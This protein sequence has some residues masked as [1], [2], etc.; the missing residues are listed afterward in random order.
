MGCILNGAATASDVW[1]SVIGG[2]STSSALTV[3]SRPPGRCTGHLVLYL[4]LFP[5]TTTSAVNSRG[6]P[7]NRAR[8]P[9]RPVARGATRRRIARVGG[10][11]GP[12]RAPS[13]AA[14]E[15]TPPRFDNDHDLSLRGAD[16]CLV[17]R[18]T[19]HT[20]RCEKTRENSRESRVSHPRESPGAARAEAASR[21]SLQCPRVPTGVALPS[22]DRCP[23][24]ARARSD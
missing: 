2:R 18:V 24:V 20:L 12:W 7:C 14:I 5:A 15:P 8:W 1:I 21:E 16:D 3:A 19:S 13:S 10:P 9:S 23:C 17:S 4:P 11:T 6:A 22:T